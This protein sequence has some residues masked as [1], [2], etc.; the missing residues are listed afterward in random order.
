LVRDKEGT[1]LALALALLVSQSSLTTDVADDDNVAR[2]DFLQQRLDQGSRNAQIWFWTWEGLYAATTVAQGVIALAVNDPEI[3]ANVLVG[4]TSS[5]IGTIAMLVPP[6]VA[7]F[8]AKRV[9]DLPDK[10]PEDRAK[11][12]VAAEQI[13]KDTVDNAEFGHSWLLHAGCAAVG[14]AGG[15]VLWLAFHYLVDGIVNTLASIAVG[16]A[17]VWTQPMRSV[18]DWQEY[19]DRFAAQPS[20]TTAGTKRSFEL[21]YG[22]FPG[23]LAIY[24]RF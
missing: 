6:F 21:H 18:R 8:A 1:M 19:Q 16:E 15:L 23:G 17:Q 10:T 5:L 7:A 13:M 9:R 14:L 12:R 2:I 4:G 11:K 3:R 24:G 20:S 22:A